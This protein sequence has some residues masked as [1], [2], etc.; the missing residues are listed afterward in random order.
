V[1][2]LEGLEGEEVLADHPAHA[3]Q[4]LGAPRRAERG[5]RAG[6]VGGL[7]T[8]P[9][10]GEQAGRATEPSASTRDLLFGE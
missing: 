7:L 10:E 2:G 4:L 1:A 5:H 9:S 6:P 8:E 3:P